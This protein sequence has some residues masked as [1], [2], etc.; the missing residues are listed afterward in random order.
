LIAREEDRIGVVPLLDCSLPFW[1]PRGGFRV[2][3]A[4]F[5]DRLA[6]DGRIGSRKA[7]AEAVEAVLDGVTSALATGESV[8]FTGFGKFSVADRAPRQG[9]NPRT[10]ERITIAG[11]RAPKFSAG[12]ALKSRV[13][14]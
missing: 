5:I 1:I 12:A 6:G 10:G 3:K 2:T 11:G 4:D 7:A 14:A 9:V 13:R 8:N